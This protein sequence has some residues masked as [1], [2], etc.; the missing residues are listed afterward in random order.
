MHVHLA[1]VP[2]HV[3]RCQRSA[4]GIEI[5]VAYVYGYIGLFGSVMARRE[6][7]RTTLVNWPWLG[8][9]RWHSL[10]AEVQS[11]WSGLQNG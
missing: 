8:G 6:F 11:G 9:I 2:S 4:A 5:E 7:G 1:A 10:E 3:A